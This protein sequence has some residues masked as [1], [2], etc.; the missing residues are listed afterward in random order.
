[1]KVI[2]LEDDRVEEV[3]DG[4]ARNYLIPK[5]L[6]VVATPQALVAAEKRREKR[7]KELEKKKE[8]MRAL[9]EKISSLEVQ[10]E[11]EAGEEGK[12]FGSVTSLDI[13]EALRKASG[14]ELDKRKV[15][16]TD[17]IKTIGEYKVLVKLFP[18]VSAT[19]KVKVSPK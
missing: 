13:V 18:E 1:M 16:L 14:I 15:E 7:K 17:P 11:V 3:S 6:A 10:L 19:L 4:Y 12:L 9:A 8:E 5:G 2:F